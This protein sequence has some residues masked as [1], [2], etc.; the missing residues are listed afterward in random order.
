MERN[1]KAWASTGFITTQYERYSNQLLA[2]VYGGGVPTYGFLLLSILLT[3]FSV[4]YALVYDWVPDYQQDPLFLLQVPFLFTRYT[5]VA[6]ILLA[7]LDPTSFVPM[8]ACALFFAYFT[9][10]LLLALAI[11]YSL[12][13][14]E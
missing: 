2:Y 10:T 7:Y 9:G 3:G 12:V 8:E 6:G 1:W 5:V 14:E 4:H 11:P 13:P